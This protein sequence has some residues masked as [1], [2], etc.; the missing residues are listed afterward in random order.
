MTDTF[1]WNHP[2]LDECQF[3]ALT[4][5]LSLRNGG[6]L[7]P[8]LKNIR[9]EEDS[10]EEEDIASV[11]DTTH[12]DEI[13]ACENEGLQKRF[14]DRFAEL[15]AC[16]RAATHVACATMMQDEESTKIWTARN[17]G[18]VEKDRGFFCQFEGFMAR[19]CS[20]DSSGEF[21][22]FRAEYLGR[23]AANELW[24]SMLHYYAHRL[25]KTYFPELKERL[26]DCLSAFKSSET[27][28]SEASD[29]RQYQNLQELYALM[30]TLA[31]SPGEEP[32]AAPS[33]VVLKAYELRQSTAI[34]E[35]LLNQKIKGASKLWI[36][37]C[38]VGRLRAAFETFIEIASKLPAFNK[39]TIYLVDSG[40]FYSQIPRKSI[41]YL[42]LAQTMKLV[43]LNDDNGTIKKYVAK[44]W[45][46]KKTAEMFE[47]R[48]QRTPR[49]HAEVQIFLSLSQQGL[50][51]DIVPY[52][53]C[54]KRSCFMCWHFLNEIGGPFTK[55]CHGKL[56]T[57]WTVPETTSLSP[58]IVK[59]IVTA[60]N[61]M[62]NLIVREILSPISAIPRLP[63]SSIGMT[64]FVDEPNLVAQ[65]ARREKL[66]E[67]S[68]E[69]Y[70]AYL[71]TKVSEL[72]SGTF[73]Q[74]Q[75]G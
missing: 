40:N 11:A 43:G 14:L 23:Q 42:G 3:I 4:T 21:E 65:Q 74:K 20:C 60:L 1:H 57:M 44:K 69:N 36:C 27:S 55:G 5:L 24:N 34:K 59:K 28:N 25:T 38:F 68:N 67:S 70:F 63:E 39:V 47:F 13:S 50:I 58:L 2:S 6:Q 18:F 48:Q 54:S 33:R 61:R 73:T 62:R 45:D 72:I 46:P 17:E 53:G 16:E 37:I 19:I 66:V 56:Y 41:Q 35:L 64:P 15:V 29:K 31:T 75:I 9:D 10:S 51:Q 49:I 8:L 30:N 26:G 52:I 7:E 71:S 12:P 22:L 32:F